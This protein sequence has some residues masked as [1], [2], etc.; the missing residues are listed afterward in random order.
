MIEPENRVTNTIHTQDLLEKLGLEKD[1][2]ERMPEI[3]LEMKGFD[4]DT[5]QVEN[6]ELFWTTH[7]NKLYRDL[8][9]YSRK[10]STNFL[11]QPENQEVK[12]DVDNPKV[13]CFVPAK[14]SYPTETEND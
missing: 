8:F 4:K 2:L 6:W 13:F 9:T 10:V 12:K 7:P 5:F 1:L 3:H 14:D 11:W